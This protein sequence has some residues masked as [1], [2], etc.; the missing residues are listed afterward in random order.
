MQDDVRIPVRYNN[1]PCYDIIL[2]DNFSFIET[3]LTQFYLTNRKVAI[4]T[5]SNVS[6]Y[7]AKALEKLLT[8]VAKEVFVYTFTAGEEN[9]NLSTVQALYE[10]LIQHSFDRNDVLFALGG[11]VVGDLTGF[12]A[13]TY[14][15][16]IR[17]F[18]VPTSLLAMVDSSIGGKTGVDF[19]AYKNMVGAFYMPAGVY[20]NLS[21][22]HSL[23][24][25]EYM[26]GMGEIIKHGLIK[27][28]QYYNWLTSNVSQIKKREIDTVLPMVRRSCEIKR[29]VVENDPKE[30]GERALLNFGHSIGHAVEKLMNFRLLHGECV[31]IGMIG[32]AYISMQRYMIS[33][34]EFEHIVATIQTFELPTSIT[35]LSVEDIIAVMSKDKK[36]D[37]GTIKFVLLHGIGNAVIDTTVSTME[38]KQAIEYLSRKNDRGL[39]II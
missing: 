32:A 2:A 29:E 38:M 25:K 3:E 7:H 4:V 21:T 33:K 15:R 22:L 13:A 10:Y 18:Q 12:T 23:P 1:V 20:M 35:G 6:K 27:D 16:G 39:T 5:D 17:F 37:A 34:E 30:Q 9:K 14:L 11:G 36:V 26:S 28:A 19:S 8:N 24:N 31:A